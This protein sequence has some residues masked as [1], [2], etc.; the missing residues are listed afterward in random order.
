MTEATN[1]DTGALALAKRNAFVLGAA[2][3][4]ITAVAPVAIATGGLAGHYLLGED[5]SWA[6]LPLMI[7]YAG[8]S[9]GAFFAAWLMRRTGRKVGFITGAFLA[10]FGC[11][12]ATIALLS[13]GF[14]VLSVGMFFIGM[15]LAFSNQFRFAAADGSPPSFKAQAISWVAVGGIFAAVIGP[16]VAI[17]MRE[18]F[19]PIPFAGS[20]AGIVPVLL[21]GIVILTFLRRTADDQPRPKGEVAEDERPLKEIIKQPKFI[22]ALACGVVSFAMMT[23]MMTGTPIAMMI[24]GFGPDQSTLGIQWHVLAMY[25]PSFFTGLLIKRF[26]ADRVTASGLVIMLIC[27]GVGFAGIELWNFWLALILLGFGWNF[28]FIGATAMVTSTYRPSEKNKIQGVHDGILFTL[29][30][31]ASLASGQVLNFWGW[32]VLVGIMWPVCGACLIMLLI[33]SAKVRQDEAATG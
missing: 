18:F 6:T 5:K 21:V 2:G 14:Y 9:L 33:Y 3:S 23:F 25:G 24:C 16:Q 20:F 22:V 4:F 32:Y 12:L 15:A 28:G 11:A 1:E 10:I 17:G 19:D 7:F 31:L 30:A 27:A 26:G 8:T 13:L 29:V